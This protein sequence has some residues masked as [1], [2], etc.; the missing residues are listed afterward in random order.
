[1]GDANLVLLEV[2]IEI[3]DRLDAFDPAGTQLEVP[4]TVPG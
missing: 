3:L 2:G 4:D 1:M